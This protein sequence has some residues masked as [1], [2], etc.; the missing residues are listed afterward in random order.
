M[1]SGSSYTIFVESGTGKGGD[2]SDNNT[3]RIVVNN[4]SQPVRGRGRG[5]G[6]GGS[7][8]DRGRGRGLERKTDLD[9]SKG[10]SQRGTGGHRPSSIGGHSGGP[11]KTGR[12]GADDDLP[13][14]ADLTVKDSHSFRGRGRGRGS[15]DN[16]E[17]QKGTEK[18][19]N[20]RDQDMSSK[21][22]PIV[23][24]HHHHHHHHGGSH[25]QKSS[26]QHQP[27]G[28]GTEHHHHHHHHHDQ[29]RKHDS[30]GQHYHHHDHHKGH[31][32]IK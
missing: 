1:A 25:Q 15:F 2:Q 24:H 19:K 16:H 27:S 7:A 28:K 21:P 23:V 5:R 18:R 20:S 26:D 32:T 3:V 14:V 30:S 31:A 12:H 8:S 11:L 29:S 4:D 10:S 6:R 13:K 9:S 17:S 22:E